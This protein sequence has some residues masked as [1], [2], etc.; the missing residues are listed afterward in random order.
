MLSA[1]DPA[2]LS[3]RTALDGECNST[4]MNNN[5]LN[6]NTN[7]I[8]NS[9]AMI[10]Q[11]FNAGNTSTVPTLLLPSS[12]TAAINSSRVDAVV[13]SASN[14]RNRVKRPMNSFLLFSN[15]M[16]PI[17][18]A[19]HKDQTNAQISKLLGQHWKALSS[20]EKRTYV[21]AASKIKTDFTA[22]HPDY[23]YTKTP[24]KHK[25]RKISTEKEYLESAERVAASLAMNH[26][27][28]YQLND[29]S[30]VSLVRSTGQVSVAQQQPP[31]MAH[32]QN[33]TAMIPQQTNQLQ[34][35][36]NTY[37]QYNSP[38]SYMVMPANPYIRPNPPQP[39]SHPQNLPSQYPP[40]TSESSTDQLYNN[41]NYNFPFD[42]TETGELQAGLP[43][44]SL[45]D[46]VL[47]DFLNL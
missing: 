43:Q 8:N 46:N 10:K 7:I 13:E 12:L 36:T 41:Y 3:G 35:V 2:T 40:T 39:I 47:S 28:R 30:G 4:S 9:R 37:A 38:S 24:R 42:S 26:D 14:K 33:Y 34:Y 25:K 44:N 17:L 27:P 1:I 45:M 22:A 21:E 5:N 6:N 15:E 11:E 18:Q 23:V 16:R 31:T 19:Q 20:E 32:V 29:V